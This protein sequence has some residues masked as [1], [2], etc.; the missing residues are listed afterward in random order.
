MT[1]WCGDDMGAFK[2]RKDD[3]RRKITEDE[4]EEIIKESF[5]VYKDKEKWSFKKAIEEKKKERE[6]KAREKLQE[7]IEEIKYTKDDFG[8]IETECPYKAKHCDITDYKEEDENSSIVLVG[9]Q[10]C[11]WCNYHHD[12]RANIVWCTAI[13]DTM[14]KEGFQFDRKGI[15][16]RTRKWLSR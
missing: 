3:P 15:R 8:C 5:D 11:V 14:N 12:K 16:K 4:A 9:S 6:E 13:R 2:R 1:E 10:P 7:E